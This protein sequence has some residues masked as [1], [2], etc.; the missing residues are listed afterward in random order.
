MLVYI[1]LLFSWYC[2]MHI[3]I[4]DMQ[5]WSLVEVSSKDS[6]PKT[7]LYEIAD[8]HYTLQDIPTDLYSTSKLRTRRQTD[9]HILS[10]PTNL[11]PSTRNTRTSPPPPH[12]TTPRPFKPAMQSMPFLLRHSL[13]SSLHFPRTTRPIRPHLTP[14]VTSSP[15]H[16]PTR[17]SSRTFTVCLRCQ[18]GSRSALYSSNESG[19]GRDGHGISETREEG[20]KD[21]PQPEEQRIEST[22]GG[23]GTGNQQ[24]RKYEQQKQEGKEDLYHEPNPDTAEGQRLPSS[25]ESRRSQW[26][27]Q[28]STM[29]DNVQSNVFVAGQRLND[30]TG[31]SSIE[32]LK[33]SI[34]SQGITLH[35]PPRAPGTPI[36]TNN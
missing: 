3:Y 17:D 4:E 22:T 33:K 16:Y 21:E 9:S 24:E 2:S 15:L 14:A 28:F 32:A 34:Q 23:T 27:K 1:R 18:F 7:K 10:D 8:K 5:A 12:H 35:P 26:S 6:T 25:M 19:K 20:V 13:R 30:L 31:Y 11:A 29:M 36:E